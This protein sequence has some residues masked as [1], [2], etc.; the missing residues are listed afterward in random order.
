L[1]LLAKATEHTLE[2]A[3]ALLLFECIAENRAE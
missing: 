1:L 3:A 2:V